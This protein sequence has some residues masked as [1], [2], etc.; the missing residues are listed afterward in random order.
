MLTELLELLFCLVGGNLYMREVS[1]QSTAMKLVLL[2]LQL[3]LGKHDEAIGIGL[4][5]L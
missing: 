1:G 3:A 2:V 4:Q 5:A